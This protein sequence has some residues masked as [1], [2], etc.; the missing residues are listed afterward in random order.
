MNEGSCCRKVKTPVYSTL[1]FNDPSSMICNHL[2]TL[3]EKVKQVQ[4]MVNAVIFPK[5]ASHVSAAMA[6]ASMTTLLQEI[7]GSTTAQ[8][9]ILAPKKT[10]KDAHWRKYNITTKEKTFTYVS[11]LPPL[12]VLL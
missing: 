8:Q 2:S 11:R 6:V 7:V 1:S 4:S 10:I 5:Q 12:R 9:E 3:V